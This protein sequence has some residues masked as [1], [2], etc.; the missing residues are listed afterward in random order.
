MQMARILL[1]LAC[2]LA[3]FAGALLF[4]DTV[5]PA[6][7]WA[8]ALALPLVGCIA[9]AGR[10]VYLGE[11]RIDSGEL[12]LLFIGWGALSLLWSPK[13]GWGGAILAQIGVGLAVYFG[14]KCFWSMAG[15]RRVGLVVGVAL[16]TIIF[17][18]LAGR[19]AGVCLTP[20][21]WTPGLSPG[22]T[23]GNRCWAGYVLALC[24]ALAV[25]HPLAAGMMLLAIGGTYSASAWIAGIIATPLLCG[26]RGWK[27]KVGVKCALVACL[28]GFIAGSY[29]RGRREASVH[30]RLLIWERAVATWTESKA[31]IVAGAGLGAT[32][33][34]VDA[35]KL[36]YVVNG[37]EGSEAHAYRANNELLQIAAETGVVGLALW[38]CFF[39][40]RIRDPL[41]ACF[42][43]I[44]MVSFPLQLAPTAVLFWAWLG[45]RDRETDNG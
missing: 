38:L 9:V 10:H 12:M 18:E 23:L 39:G 30:G 44:A 31:S 7:A 42:A 6:W 22:A 16:S 2:G 1:S 13:P 35:H 8:A 25:G 41:T 26:R 14:A 15:L 19:A 3:P 20:W 5:L 17:L 27:V 11:R 34:A 21:A 29:V 43:W 45:I 40:P 37:A 24:S 33:D 36:G 4:E 28:L 32:V